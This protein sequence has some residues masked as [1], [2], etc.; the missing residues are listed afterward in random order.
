MASKILKL[1]AVLFCFSVGAN[2]INSGPQQYIEGL[3]KAGTPSYILN[4]ACQ[5]NEANITDS[6]NIVTRVATGGLSD[7]G[8]DCQ[9]DADASGEK[10]VWAWRAY[11]LRL[12]SQNCE[13]IG[14]YKGDASLYKINVV[15]D[16][17]TVNSVQLTNS[18]AG[19]V[20]SIN[21][22]CGADNA[23]LVTTE[24][25]ATDNAAAL[26]NF[27][28]LHGGEATNIG[29]VA[30][31]EACLQARRA[32]S[33]QSIG[34]AAVTTIIYNSTVSQGNCGSLNTSTG[35]F[36]VSKSKNY[37]LEASALPL[38]GANE[39][40]VM[41][42]SH[43]DASA[44]TTN[45]YI[46]YRGNPTQSPLF[47]GRSAL[48]AADA[49]DTLSITID[50]AADTSYEIANAEDS[51]FNITAFPTAS[52][53]VFKVGQAGLEWT[54]W[55]P[56][57]TLT[58]NATTVGEYQ[59][60]GDNFVARVHTAFTGTNTQGGY[61]VTLPTSFTIDTAKLATTSGNSY[62]LGGGS[63]LDSG[64]TIIPL[65]VSYSSTT[66]V[67]IGWHF[68]SGTPINIAG[69]NTTTNSPVTVANG[70]YISVY[71]TVPVTASSP[72]PRTPMPLFK[73]AVTTGRTS[74]AKDGM[75]TLECDA[76][77]QIISNP[78]SMVATFGNQ[79]GSTCSGTFTTGF[80]TSAPLCFVSNANNEARL[81]SMAQGSITTTA[82]NIN[83]RDLIGNQTGTVNLFCRGN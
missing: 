4:P 31:A 35:V 20:V 44:S 68:A 67:Q 36:T 19:Q 40:F 74:T 25:E 33:D 26:I 5:K 10:A 34:S 83:I 72:C 80:F 47:V 81:P 1:I 3:A 24:L 38:N 16:A 57:T 22:P 76:S 78:D 37:Q 69:I 65:S 64:T 62:T 48:I 2:S 45:T 15:Q 28:W 82:F 63:Y 70:D 75:A 14:Y 56:T 66:A 46:I 8:T 12:E 54:Q 21:F 41:R 58:T 30:Q 13:A 79:S 6:D 53:Q 51:A 7:L 9:I 49:G 18:T 43:F 11:P 27:M 73:N 42:A 61:Q 71:F 17:V 29:S 59:C 55:S 39:S 32:T 23:D 52:E 50:S 60:Q 77:S